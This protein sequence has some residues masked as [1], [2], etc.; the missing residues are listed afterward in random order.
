MSNGPAP[1]NPFTFRLG[2][3]ADLPACLSALRP[4]DPARRMPGVELVQ[5]WQRCL[6]LGAFVVIE[7][8]GKAWA[9]AIEGFG[10]SVFVSD[11]FAD[12][13][14]TDPRPGVT[15]EFFERLAA[16]QSLCLS[17][18]Q[19]SQA[20][21]GAGINVLV[22]HFGS[23]LTDF[24]DARTLALHALVGSSFY[25]SHGGHRIR[26][27]LAETYG[28]DAT[29]FA[30]EGQFRLLKDFSAASPDAYAHVPTQ[31]RPYLV[32]LRREWVRGAGWYPM[33]QLFSR[34]E[35]RIH[36]SR[37]Q[38]RVLERALLGESEQ[39]IAA[40]LGLSSHTVKSAWKN[41]IQRAGDTIEGLF[42]AESAAQSPTRGREKRAHLLAYLRNHM[43]E[44]RPYPRPRRIAVVG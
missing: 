20:N 10:L 27:I 23:R 6:D 3:P 25:F 32:G 11:A 41:A 8:I 30:E 1:L 33:A 35:P 29:R 42:P 18:Q 4:G 12:R 17:E 22:L 16:G 21:A 39:T 40:A 14:F 24:S 26:S 19:V 15:L 37:T 5:L 36:F 38:R 34:L 9:G 7:R 28:R 31:E 13:Y 2:V 43:E 44:L